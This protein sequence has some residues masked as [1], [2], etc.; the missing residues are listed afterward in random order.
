MNYESVQNEVYEMLQKQLDPRYVY[1]NV[2]HTFDVVESAVRIAEYEQLGKED[3]VLL[4]TAALFHDIGFTRMYH[5]NEEV[6]AQIAAEI[7]PRFQY[8]EAQIE[9]IGQMIRYTAFPV[10]PEG[11]LNCLLCDADLDYLGRDDYFNKSMLLFREWR[12]MGVD[13]DLLKWYRLQIDFLEAHTFHSDFSKKYRENKKNDILSQI[14][15]LL[16]N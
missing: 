11:Y 13:I 10:K 14:K 12:T 1:H 2:N 5:D 16:H 3:S 4:K 8:S 7:L 9:K 15:Q 6:S